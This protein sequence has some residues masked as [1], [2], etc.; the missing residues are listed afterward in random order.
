MKKLHAIL[1]AGTIFLALAAQSASA[2]ELSGTGGN[3]CDLPDLSGSKILLDPAC[4]YKAGIRISKSDTV[5]DCRGA[6]IDASDKHNGILIKGKNIENVHVLNCNIE[7][8]K[9]QGIIVAAPLPDA[10]ITA[11]PMEERYAIGPK[12]IVIEKSTV[13]K[14]ASVGIYVDSYA[15]D[16]KLLH[17]NVTGNGGA[18]VYLEHSSVKT[19]IEGSRITENGFGDPLGRR[20][21]ARREGIA[22][23]SSAHNIIRDNIISGNSQG[24]IFLYKNCW[25]H[26][27][28]PGT[29]AR[30]QH[31]AYN[32]IVDNTFDNE[33]VGIWVGSR[34]GKNLT[35]MNCGDPEL[36][37]GYFRDYA[38][39]NT[40]KDNT[41]R[42]VKVGIRV[43]DSDTAVVDNKIDSAS[44]ACIEVGAPIL[45]QLGVIVS[46][47]KI[48]NN[49]CNVGAP[50]AGASETALTC[51]ADTA[52][53]A[54][55]SCP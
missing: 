26:H 40:L 12:N 16:V 53:G 5:L 54:V 50:S 36:A 49:H 11:L 18:G 9:A 51:P 3:T 31:A 34:Q 43:F 28:K 14:S 1:R 45:N 21:G 39:H 19:Q 4:T 10:E 8:A 42:N 17:V 30:W 46:G 37:P 47:T 6:R 13:T 48:D 7:G 24:G 32:D 35:S 38:D 44:Q 22:I 55:Y 20:K 52:A 29:V 33:A 23:D 15:Q 25:E 27:D 41:F 2:Q